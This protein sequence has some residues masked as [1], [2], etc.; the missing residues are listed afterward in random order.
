[1]SGNNYPLNLEQIKA[2]IFI[3][4]S[5]I[6][7]AKN[8]T[9]KAAK[10]IKAQAGYHLQQAAE[11]MI[12]IQIYYSG[13]NLDLNKM[14]KHPLPNL[15]AYAQSLGVNLI[16]PRY[17]QQNQVPISAWEAQGRYDVH[18]VVKIMQLEKA[19]EEIENWCEELKNNGYK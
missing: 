12:K 8:R 4:K 10:Y 15:I 5:M 16:V 1:M 18:M 13:Q 11:K 7:E 9:P 6:V 14:Y 2:D 19:Y 17:V 3:A